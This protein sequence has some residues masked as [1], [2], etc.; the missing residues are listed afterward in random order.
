MF[1]CII[2]L[3]IVNFLS[4]AIVLK[5]N[6]WA[7]KNYTRFFGRIINKINPFLQYYLV[8]LPLFALM[9]F[10]LGSKFDFKSPWC[11]WPLP[12]TAFVIGE[13]MS[14]KIGALRKK[15]IKDLS[16][17]SLQPANKQDLEKLIHIPAEIKSQTDDPSTVA[18][19]EEKLAQIKGDYDLSK[20]P[21]VIEITRFPKLLRF[22]LI[23]FTLIGGF[24]LTVLAFTE[25]YTFAILGVPLLFVSIFQIFLGPLTRYM[26]RDSL[27]EIE[28]KYPDIKIDTK[29]TNY[30]FTRNSLYVL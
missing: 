10:N 22:L 26:F 4:Y 3:A 29:Q 16:S 17:D 8:L 18:R 19:M 30:V 21:F 6:K 15:K 9:I 24:F 5:A 1:S 2:V 14:R 20:L 12:V 28:A 11:W 7:L 27:K 25:D 13:Y 23:P